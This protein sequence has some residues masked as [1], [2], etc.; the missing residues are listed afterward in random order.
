MTIAQKQI[1]QNIRNFLLTATAEQLQAEYQISVDS[2]DNFRAMC[3]NEIILENEENES[4]EELRR[5]E[6]KATL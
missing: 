4:L 3:V 6:S 2:G 5:L 1:R